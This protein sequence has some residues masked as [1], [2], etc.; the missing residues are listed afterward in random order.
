M[1]RLPA[2]VMGSLLLAAGAATGQVVV[3]GGA[4]PADL[5]SVAAELLAQRHDLSDPVVR[6]AVVRQLR[7][8]A[9]AERAYTVQRAGELGLPL[10]TG[11]GAVLVGFEGDLPL[12]DQHDNQRAAISTATNLVRNAVPFDVD[13]AGYLI[14]MWESGGLPRRTHQ[15]LNGR[16]THD[17]FN[18]N[19]SHAT[20]V[21]GTLIAAGISPALEGM[22]PAAS[23][24]AYDS[25]AEVAEMTEIAAAAPGQPGKIY[26]SNHSYS[27]LSGWTTDPWRW[28]GTFSDDGN[29]A[30]DHPHHFGRY[31]STT[32]SWDGLVWN[33]QYYLPIKSAGNHRNDNHPSNGTSW[34]LNGSV[35]S[36]YNY[37]SD[38]HPPGDFEYRVSGGVTGYDT[39]S[40][41]GCAKNTMTVGSVADAVTNNSRDVAK[42]N[43]SSFSSAGPAD[44]GRIKPD[45][46]ANGSSLLSLDDDSDTD[47]TTKSGTSMSS[48][49]ACG[50]ALLLQDYYD[51]RF[52]GDAMRASTLKGLI[53]HTADDRGNPGPDYRYGWGLMNAPAAANLIKEH[54]DAP[55]FRRLLESTLTSGTPSQVLPFF[56]DGSGPIRITLCW[57]DPPGQSTGTHDSRT[58]CL[59]HDLNL[60]LTAPDGT[61]H[62]HP[63]VMPWVGDWS[64]AMLDADATTGVNS[65]DNVEQVLVAAPVQD[66]EYTVTIDH[67]GSLS[68]GPQVYSVVVS[69]GVVPEGYALWA[70]RNY[71]LDWGD[72]SVAGFDRD[73]EGDGID[74]GI[75][76]AFDLAAAA[77]QVQS[78]DVYTVV[79]DV[80]GADRYL[81]LQYERDTTKT[82]ISYE[83]EWSADLVTWHDLDESVESVAGDIETVKSRVMVDGVRKFLRLVIA[84][85]E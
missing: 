65:V 26:V 67:A 32:M 80:E 74:N 27:G 69:G 71:P 63:F 18:F 46:V 16:V 37:D 22:A 83:V 49:N 20:H 25:G 36:Q 13:G 39:I 31:R 47:T 24:I 53:L 19:S 58:P 43:L 64:D 28:Y 29:A 59:V 30:N 6:E 55:G 17:D 61:T 12:Y 15:E 84:R 54:A 4:T 11:S 56:R 34:R 9:E 2:K 10:A 42:A 3:P 21:A 14:G 38:S 8:A 57:T 60:K 68:Q 41:R 66:G 82:D 73:P 62:F 51:D 44:D 1:A 81:G 75:E 50:S 35:S 7:E 23:L 48:P 70:A 33:A 52:P 72:E 76:Y 5:D 85:L 40:Y 78:A 77:T 79:E 45:I